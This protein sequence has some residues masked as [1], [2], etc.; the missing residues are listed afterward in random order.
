MANTQMKPPASSILD[1]SI[2]RLV[3]VNLAALYAILLQLE[4]MKFQTMMPTTSNDINIYGLNLVCPET[5]KAWMIS[6]TT[7]VAKI[8]C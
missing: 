4:D 8:N 7:L 6:E 1:A 3:A 5:H 2:E